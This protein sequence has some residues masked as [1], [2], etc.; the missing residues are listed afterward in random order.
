MEYPWAGQV[1]CKARQIGKTT[2][3]Q[4]WSKFLYIKPTNKESNMPLFEVAIIER[5]TPNDEDAGVPEKLIYGPKA[6]IAA[7]KEGAIMAASTEAKL[8]GDQSRLE[9]LVRPF[10]A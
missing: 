10:L 1:I 7:T 9:V 2:C 4:D 6:V 8:T 3:F 5:P